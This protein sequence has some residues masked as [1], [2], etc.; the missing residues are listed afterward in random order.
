LA[1]AV[2]FEAFLS[3]ASAGSSWKETG[4]DCGACRQRGLCSARGCDGIPRPDPV[5]LDDD[6]ALTT[7]PVLEF[8][9]FVDEVLSWFGSTYDLELGV[10]VA[11]WRMTTLPY[12]GA[13]AEQP[14]K[15]MEALTF[16]ADVR[17]TQLLSERKPRE[18]RRRAPKRG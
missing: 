18:R 8:T 4:R 15:L 6:V 2:R 7:C 3:R 14:A 12:P 17:N 1:L 11:R 10:G 13:L 9:P 16:V 5:W